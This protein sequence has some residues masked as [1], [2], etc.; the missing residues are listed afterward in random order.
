L[1]AHKDAFATPI[2]RGVSGGF[3]RLY[4]SPNDL[5]VATVKKN[6]LKRFFST[7]FG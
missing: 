6:P 3:L 5:P 1:V 2:C 4:P 7:L